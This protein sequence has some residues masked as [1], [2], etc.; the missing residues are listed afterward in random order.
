[1]MRH[2]GFAVFILSHGRAD[3]MVTLKTLKKGGYT[4]Q[5]YILV[6]DEDSQQGKYKEKY[7]E[8]VIVFNKRECANKCDQGDTSE[9][10]RVILFA[11]NQCF[12]EAERLGLQSFLELDDDYTSF[13]YR[14]QEGDRLKVR[15]YK[16]LDSLFDLMLDF[17]YNTDAL[18]V[19][20]AQGGDFIG[21]VNGGI[22]QK[23]IA[24]KA[25]NTFFCRTDKRF[26]FVGR[27]NED[28]NTYT[29]LGQRGEKIFTF[30][31]AAIVQKTTQKNNGGMS[32]IY[33]DMG[34]Y[35]KSFYSVMY[36]PSCV[37]IS[38]MGDKHMRIHHEVEW[39][40]CTPMILNEKYKK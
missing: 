14:Y 18:T 13:E 29:T 22:F 40:Y 21:G 36:S 11:R 5:V 30:T 6:D 9:D 19:A 32:D 8:D 7:G 12:D 16:D 23:G 25:M 15:K 1:M 4:G 37:K 27:I 2:K 20:L 28:V 31:K 3:N 26:A 35:L 38:K 33:L 10:R 24:R 39:D 34:T 17:L